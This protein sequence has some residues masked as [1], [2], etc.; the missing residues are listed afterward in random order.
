M[1]I[2]LAE[3]KT[4]FNK[5][6][7]GLYEEPELGALYRLL[8]EHFLGFDS[9]QL[10]LHAQRIL[11]E[12][13]LQNLTV[14]LKRLTR[15][16][17]IQYILGE[18]HFY[19]LTFKVSEGILIP[20]QETEILVHTII[21]KA[22]GEYKSPK[23]LD[24]GT[25]SG[26]IAIALQKNIAGS[27]VFAVDVSDKALEIAKANAQLNQSQ[28][29]FQKLNILETPANTSIGQFDIVV[30]NPPYVL[31]SEKEQMHRNVVDFEPELAL[32][33]NDNNPLLYYKEITGFCREH[34]IEGGTLVFEINEKFGWDIKSL[35][36]E[37]G[38]CKVEIIQDL[39]NKDRVV[40]GIKK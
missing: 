1:S 3:F 39:N 27:S 29:H 40:L 21:H 25:G 38:F 34:L 5:S 16:E 9:I 20:R 6:L 7:S 36:E 4:H 30:S 28:V 37:N 17:P 18:A 22:K 13:E 35:M 10:A 8:L 32:Y 33:V 15:S 24:I 12:S 23:L 2:S 31:H 11:E 26:C 14:A 19:G